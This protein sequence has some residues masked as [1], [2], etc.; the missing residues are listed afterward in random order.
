MAMSSTEGGCRCVDSPCCDLGK[1]GHA[2]LDGRGAAL[3]ADVI[4]VTG[5]EAEMIRQVREL[6]CGG[7]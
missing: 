3:E 7:S 5:D 6:R 1:G 2:E 4:K